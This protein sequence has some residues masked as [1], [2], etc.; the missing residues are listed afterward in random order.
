MGCRVIHGP[1]KKVDP[2]LLAS[3]LGGLDSDRVEVGFDLFR[4]DGWADLGIKDVQ[5]LIVDEH[6]RYPSSGFMFFIRR[7]VVCEF[8]G[9]QATKLGFFF[10]GELC[11]R[12]FNKPFG[13]L[14]DDFVS[15]PECKRHPG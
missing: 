6:S 2:A 5:T 3:F 8:F 1:Q 11:A 7:N 14:F 15:G 10:V 13:R 4:R 12:V 9:G